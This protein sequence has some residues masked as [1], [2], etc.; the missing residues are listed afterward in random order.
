MPNI[1]AV[2]VAIV[3]YGLGNLFSIRH[4]CERA[5]LQTIISSSPR[6]ISATDAVILP[7]V[8]AFGDAMQSL[9][10]LD[11][12]SCLQDI[13]SSP[14]PL[15]G[16]CLGMQLMLT[17]GHEFGTHR[18]LGIIEGE[19]VRL[20]EPVDGKRSFKIPQIGWNQIHLTG[21]NYTVGGP[22]TNW[23]S[24]MLAGVPDMEYMY[25]SHS[26]YAKPT[27]SNVVVSTTRYGTTEFCSSIRLGSIFAYQFHPE[28]SG[29]SGLRIYENLAEMIRTQNPEQINV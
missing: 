19:V 24:P 20:E 23:K 3:D 21:Y 6:E 12:V 7:G 22:E 27:N 13:A 8:G 11:L 16:I 26:F 4:A 10:K 5:G 14:K 9:A 17:E 28:R 18:G 1:S 2:R 15:V 29:S 25:F